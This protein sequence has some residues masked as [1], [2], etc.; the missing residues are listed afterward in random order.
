MARGDIINSSIETL[1]FDE[2]QGV[3]CKI[4]Q[5]SGGVCAIVYANTDNLKM[6]TYLIDS[7]GNIGD[8]IDSVVIGVGSY[9]YIHHITDT[10]VF[11]IAYVGPSADRFVKLLTINISNAGIIGSEI[12]S[13]DIYD[14][15]PD[16]ARYLKL[17][18]VSGTTYAIT[19]YIAGTPPDYPGWLAT[20]NID[21]DGTNLSVLDSYNFSANAV[22]PDI[23]R[24]YGNVFIITHNG[25]LAITLPIAANGTIGSVLDSH[26]FL[27]ATGYPSL[28]HIAGNVFATASYDGL[29]GW[30]RTFSVISGIITEI[31]TYEFAGDASAIRGLYLTS[32]GTNVIIAVVFTTAPSPPLGKIY[33]IYIGIDGI[34]GG[35]IDSD[36]WK[37][38]V[39][40]PYIINVTGNIYA[41]VCDGYGPVGGG[42]WLVTLS[43]DTIWYRAFK[44]LFNRGDEIQAI[45]EGGVGYRS[46]DFGV[47]WY[48]ME[49]EPITGRDVGFDASNEQ[50]SFIGASG[51]LYKFD[52]AE[53]EIFYY[54]QGA[55]ISGVVSCID[56]DPVTPVAVVG[57]SEKL[58]KTVDFG[59]TVHEWKSIPVAGV[60]IG[61]N[62][63]VP[64]G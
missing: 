43:I 34:I 45:F 15:S 33:T 60:A 32:D 16:V 50:E 8:E 48:E 20:V 49:D 58:Y 62:F 47:T 30:I 6:K 7:L 61:G 35:Q 46:P 64:S 41:L 19:W 12:S 1:E 21:N 10:N 31:D 5:V 29:P 36:Q 22:S 63:I 51:V 3:Y 52:Y 56:V 17:V 39:S 55:A 14:P 24:A 4:V 23:M 53:G 25:G 2:D 18:H 37:S 42:G 40:T 44:G 11:A 26:D 54:A 28:I 38:T 13:L 57:T 59:A 27:V 9:P